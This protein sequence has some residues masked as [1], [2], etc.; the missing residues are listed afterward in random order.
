MALCLDWAP[1]TTK[2]APTASVPVD[3][4]LL[5]GPR[6]GLVHVEPWP[7]ATP[8]LTVH[9]EGRR[10]QGR[11]ADEREM[12]HAMTEAPWERLELRLEPRDR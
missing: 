12:R 8:S 7:F 4:E 9:C 1:A 3:L 10:L 11:F 2:G 6:P 5:P